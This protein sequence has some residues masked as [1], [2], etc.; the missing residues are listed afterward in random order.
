MTTTA[1][2]PAQS[3]AALKRANEIRLA[4]AELR[5]RI[6]R[7]EI[8]PASVLLSPP[9]EARTWAIGDLL[10]SQRHWGTRRMHRLLAPER[11]SEVKPVGELTERQRRVL[12]RAL[13]S[14]GEAPAS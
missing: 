4:R 7:G 13:G 3:R 10:V 5:H 14:D 12:A 9:E 1:P 6:A 2:S 11:I 8:F